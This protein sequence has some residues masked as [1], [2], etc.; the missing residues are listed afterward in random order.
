MIDFNTYI[1]DNEINITPVDWQ[2]ICSSFSKEEIIDSLATTISSGLVNLPLKDITL[3]QAIEAQKGLMN[4][5]TSLKEGK[6]FT[7]YETNLDDYYFDES[8]NFNDASNYFHQLSRY[9]ADSVNSPSPVRTWNTYK[10]AH[11]MVSALFS[12]KCKEVNKQTLH[13]CLAMRK[14]IASQF[15]PSVAK[16]VYDHFEGKN[17]VDL[18]SGWGDRLSGF[19]ASNGTKSY[20]GIDPNSSLCDGYNR[21]I[22][23]YNKLVKKDTEMVCQAAEDEVVKLPTCDLVF[24]SPP[25]FG[26]EKYSK[27]DN[28]SYLRYRKIDSWLVNFLFKIIQ[29]S[30]NALEKDGHL[31]LN[32]SD[33]YMNHTIN[34]ICEPMIEYCKA[35]GFKH[36]GTWGMRMAKRT[37]SKSDND[38]IFC[39]PIY[40]FEK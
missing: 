5:K 10:F 1:K 27:D 30:Y 36:I 19:Y 16:A 4:Y 39:E 6:I 29:K 23:E 8:S 34:K 11:S 37:N 24:T 21:Q 3:E 9:S 14:Y 40:V 35:L 31:V 15:K 20:F 18:C 28:Q 26:V 12:L 32:I 22:I 33:V 17:V 25:Y 2:G 7:R 13:S 38:G